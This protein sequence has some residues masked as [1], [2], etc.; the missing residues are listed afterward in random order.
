LFTNLLTNNSKLV[1]YL[2]IIFKY[3][4]KLINLYFFN[5][6]F[7][8]K[9]YKFL[10]SSLKYFNTPL[11]SYSLSIF[12]INSNNSFKYK[13]FAAYYTLYLIV[14]IIIGNEISL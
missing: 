7:L 14:F 8:I 2:V 3:I 9:N 4:A 10:Y 1:F 5:F 6:F 11:L 12:T 13:K